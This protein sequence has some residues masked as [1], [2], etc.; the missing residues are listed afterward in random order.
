MSEIALFNGHFQNAYVVRDAEAAMRRFTDRYGVRK[1]DVLD[2]TIL[3]A[4]SGVRHICNTFVGERMIEL[5]DPDP[6]VRTIYSDWAPD[7]DDAARLHH[8][9]FW[10]RSATDFAATVACLSAAGHATAM[11]GSFGEMLDFHYADTTAELGH[12][13]EL[14]HVR[15]AGE[16]FF[17]RMPRN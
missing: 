10:T 17:A 6:A 7:R 4:A 14:I 3:G 12:F 2:Q 8:L 9:G 13:Y 15:P 11:A 1:W 16:E 5:I